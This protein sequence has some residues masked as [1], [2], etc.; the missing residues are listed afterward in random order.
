MGF[1]FIC[2]LL[3]SAFIFY[4]LCLFVIEYQNGRSRRLNR[5]WS[6]RMR[7]LAEHTSPSASEGDP[8]AA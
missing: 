4:G 1:I 3:L 6:D 2:F 8:K 7:S 5:L